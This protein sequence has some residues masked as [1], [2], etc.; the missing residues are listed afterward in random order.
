MVG[1]DLSEVLVK[2]GLSSLSHKIQELQYEL[3][4][5]TVGYLG[6]IQN[7]KSG[8][9]PEKGQYITSLPGVNDV[10]TFM[11]E[12]IMRE[13]NDASM[14][15]SKIYS[16]HAFQ[17]LVASGYIPIA[18]LEKTYPED[19]PVRFNTIKNLWDAMLTD[20]AGI[21]IRRDFIY[22]RFRTIGMLTC[23]TEGYEKEKLLYFLIPNNQ[24]DLEFLKSWIS[25][26]SIHEVLVLTEAEYAAKVVDQNYDFLFKFDKIVDPYKGITFRISTEIKATIPTYLAEIGCDTMCCFPEKESSDKYMVDSNRLIIKEFQK[27][28]SIQFAVS[29]PANYTIDYICLNGIPHFFGTAD[30]DAAGIM[31]TKSDNGI[32]TNYNK[33]IVTVSGIRESTKIYVDACEDLTG[34]TSVRN[35]ISKDKSSVEFDG[36]I[37]KVRIQFNHPFIFFNKEKVKIYARKDETAFEELVGAVEVLVDGYHMVEKRAVFGNVYFNMSSDATYN[38]RVTPERPMDGPDNPDP[39]KR[40]DNPYVVHYLPRY[41][42]PFAQNVATEVGPESRAILFNVSESGAIVLVFEGYTDYKYFRV[43]F[44]DRAMV[45]VYRITGSSSNDLDVIPVIEDYVFE[46]PITEEDNGIDTTDDL[47]DGENITDDF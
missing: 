38:N 33:F 43:T 37:T 4:I 32:I 16:D 1:F 17:I 47:D 31:I 7:M 15:L 12:A 18:W 10:C 29:A 8:T 19:A 36:D 3:S 21:S 41:M 9:R 44:E 14:Y 35:M 5:Q 13:N 39:M 20:Y 25:Q 22:T 28:D 30:L 26:N 46:R 42:S 40:R 45:A 11:N 6:N 24:P 2:S 27:G 34:K 23:R